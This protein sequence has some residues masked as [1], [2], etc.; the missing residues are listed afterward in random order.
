MNRDRIVSSP[1]LAGRVSR[2]HTWPTLTQQTNADH[3]WHVMRLYW[4]I[5][6][7]MSPEVSSYLLWHDG[8]EIGCGDLPFPVKSR[9]PELKERFD[10][11][12][13]EALRRVGGSRAS[14]AISQ[15]SDV[16][17]IRCKV[18]DLLEMHEFGLMEMMMGN[19]LAE[20]IVNDTMEALQSVAAR[21]PSE[22]RPLVLAYIQDNCSQW[23]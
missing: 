17:R 14:E 22:D 4:S 7:A 3:T 8:G 18:C 11:L 19:R 13:H 5:F 2:Y 9:D 15:L 6:G 10:A 21:L 1:R 23:R 12:E 16:D 20:P